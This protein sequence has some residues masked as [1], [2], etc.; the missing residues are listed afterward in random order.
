MAR[1]TED[2]RMEDSRAEGHPELDAKEGHLRGRG[3]RASTGARP[4][5]RGTVYFLMR[6][7]RP[8]V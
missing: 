3:G 7:W 5:P 8:E 2:P 6:E 1:P 4:H